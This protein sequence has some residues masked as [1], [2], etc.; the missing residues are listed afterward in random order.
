MT[1]NRKLYPKD[2]E[3]ISRRIRFERAQNRCEWCRAMNYAAHPITG[4]KVVLTVAHLDHTPTN[5]ADKNLVALCQ[6]C[7][8]G[9]DLHRHL[10]R[11]KVNRIMKGN[12]DEVEKERLLVVWRAHYKNVQEMKNRT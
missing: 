8:L 3:A 4:S 9:Y 5:C 1:L 2:W 7:H 12:D 6:K 10:A 11:R